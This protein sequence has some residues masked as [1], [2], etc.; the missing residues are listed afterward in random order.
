MEAGQTGSQV[1]RM[2]SELPGWGIVNQTK[3][4]ANKHNSDLDNSTEVGQ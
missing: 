2:V 1:L 4:M 3:E